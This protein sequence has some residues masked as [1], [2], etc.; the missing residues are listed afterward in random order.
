MTDTRFWVY[1]L[2]SF[3]PAHNCKVKYHSSSQKYMK[4]PSAQVCNSGLL[5]KDK[6]NLTHHFTKTTKKSHLPG[7]KSLP[8]TGQVMWM[9]RKTEGSEDPTV[10]MWVPSSRSNGSCQ[11]KVLCLLNHNNL[12]VIYSIFSLKTAFSFISLTLPN[13]P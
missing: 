4:E 9:W 8:K 6:P 3:L 10:H 11:N 7:D 12:L 1:P 2:V 13:K 5:I